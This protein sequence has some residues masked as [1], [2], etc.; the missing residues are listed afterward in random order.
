MTP[1]FTATLVFI[2][3]LG[4]ALLGM[5]GG[6]LMPEREVAGESKD[7]VRVTMGLTTTMTA[8]LLGLVTAESKSA[9][10]ARDAA[11]K[12]S[13]VNLLAVDRLRARYGPETKD[14]REQLRVAMEAR[15]RSIWSEHSGAQSAV[16][17][18]TMGEKIEDRIRALSPQSD[19]QRWFQARAMDASGDLL[20]TRWLVLGMVGSSVPGAF[21]TA[22][23]AWLTILFASFGLFAPRRAVVIG[24]LAFCAVSVASAIF[25]ILELDGPS[26][27]F[28]QISDVPLR[29][30]ISQIGK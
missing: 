22:M 21:L 24:A 28:I 7:V 18:I 2:C 29:F 6:A 19:A 4:G 13:M 17:D 25:L 3:V 1:L 15:V 16:P 30:A 8:I 26:S 9:F 27:G 12:Q 14:I 11:I 10:D 20:R 5:L 23:V